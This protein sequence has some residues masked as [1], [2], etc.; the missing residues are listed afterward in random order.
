[1]GLDSIE[2]ILATE[3]EFGIEI[4]DADAANLLTPRQLAAHVSQLLGQQAENAPPCPTQAAFYRTRRA[5]CQLFGEK[6]EHIRPD[7]PIAPY[8]AARPRAQ[9]RQLAQAIDAPQLPHLCCPRW[10]SRSLGITSPLLALLWGIHSQQPPWALLLTPLIAF[11]LASWLLDRIAWQLPA[12][13]RKVSDLLPYVRNSNPNAWN[14][15]YVLQRV[16]QITATE[17]GLNLNA[18]NPDSRFVED[19][20]I[21]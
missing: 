9:W 14:A 15:A 20:G 12:H 18:F 8:L 10:L 5:L 7:T 21:D 11:V 13:L 4:A 19:L 1:M 3:A 2:L 6:R 17:L 16:M